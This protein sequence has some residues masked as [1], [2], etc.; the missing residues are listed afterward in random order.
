MKTLTL[1]VEDVRECE[2][3]VIEEYGFPSFL[4][5]E[6]AGRGLSDQVMSTLSRFPRTTQVVALCGGG[7]NGGDGFVAARHL[8][9]KHPCVS[10]YLLSDPKELKGDA[11]LNYQLLLKLN[12]PLYPFSAFSEH[13]KTLFQNTPLII[14]DA[15]LG[16]G[17]KGPLKPEIIHAVNQ[18][19]ELKKYHNAKV[20]VIAVDIP[21]GLN[22]NE[23]PSVSPT[24]TNPVMMADMTVTFGFLKK[25]LLD[26]HS[27]PFVGRIEVVDIGIPV[28]IMKSLG[29]FN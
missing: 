23:G 26:E 18:I 1:S 3:R 15:I 2:R 27:K 20:N 12:L 21:T 8:S 6:N 17:F 22:G 14:L 25:G 5:M 24:Q 13:R 10:V 16:T 11:L 9:Q 4:L 7:N 19:N 29:Y 28:Q